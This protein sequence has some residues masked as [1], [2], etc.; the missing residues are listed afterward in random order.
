MDIDLCCFYGTM[1]QNLLHTA[2]IHALFYQIGR[3]RMT[4][5]MWGYVSFDAGLVC[6]F[7][8]HQADGLLC[9]SASP[10]VY[11]EKAAVLDL[12]FIF[13]VIFFQ[14]GKHSGIADLDVSLFVSFSH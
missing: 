2:Y 8:Q 14:Y 10:A 9:K 13:F 5:H 4:E 7:F 6:V 1:P 11:K 3:K 12:C